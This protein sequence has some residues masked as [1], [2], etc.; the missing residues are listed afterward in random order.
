MTDLVEGGIDVAIRVGPLADTRFIARRLTASRA[1]TIAAASYLARRGTPRHPDDLRTHD[2][3]NIRFRNSGQTLRWHL[4]VDGRE[5]EFEPQAMMTADN[6][7]AV[8][9]M[10]VAGGGIGVSPAFVA[11]PLVQAGLVV[12]VPR[13]FMAKVCPDPAPYTQAIFAS[14]RD[15][16]T[17]G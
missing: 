11:P 10:V 14:L 5:I 6:S 15:R 13:E 16:R 1:C 8:L 17:V 12:P 2:C 9:A 3:A 4:I 7:D